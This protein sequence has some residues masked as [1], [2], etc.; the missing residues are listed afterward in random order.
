MRLGD[1]IDSG[2]IL[3]ET[4]EDS[5]QAVSALAALLQKQGCVTSAEAFCEAVA[6]HEAEAAS[7]LSPQIAVPHATSDTVLR[8]SIAVGRTKDRRTVF[9]IASD[10]ADNHIRSLSALAGA[11]LEDG[12]TEKIFEET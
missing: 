9:L 3:Y 11:L 8:P 1:L 12:N 5:R 6:R 2:L 7:E 10:N 4:A